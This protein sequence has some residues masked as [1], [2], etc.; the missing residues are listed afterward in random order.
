MNETGQNQHRS[1]VVERTLL[2]G[3][4]HYLAILLRYRWLIIGITGAVALGAVAFS[5]VSLLLPPEKSPLPNRYTAN[6]TLLVQ[7]G[8]GDNL[9]ASILA[10][11]GIE[12]QPTD[13]ALGFEIGSLLVL[14]LQSRTLL[15]K[16][17]EEFHLVERYRFRR[18]GKEPIEADAA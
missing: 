15:D 16:V 13:T 2:E 1:S 3:L 7:K 6:A 4:L 9:S 5:V 10:A 8:M 14:V 17:I 18:S 11:L 12:S